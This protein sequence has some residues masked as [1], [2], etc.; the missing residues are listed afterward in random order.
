MI[1]YY[2]FWKKEGQSRIQQSPPLTIISYAA[3]ILAIFI[4]AGKVFSPQFL[5]WIVPLVPLI[6]GRYSLLIKMLFAVILLL[7]QIEFP[8]NYPLLLQLKPSVLMDVA[9]RNILV[10]LLAMLLIINGKRRFSPDVADAL[11]TDVA[12]AL[13]TDEAAALAPEGAAT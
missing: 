13:A 8:H 4:F 12:D 5:L 6:Y 11:A 7:T 1:S 10:G 9:I 2:F 3:A